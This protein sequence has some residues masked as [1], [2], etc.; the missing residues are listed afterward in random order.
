MSIA[1]STNQTKSRSEVGISHK[2]EDSMFKIESGIIIPPK[3]AT[4]YQQLRQFLPSLK[5]KQS[6]YNPEKTR[7]FQAYVLLAARSLGMKVTTRQVGK[8]IRVWRV[9]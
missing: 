5:P 2:K 6:F 3:R 8:G 9:S 4:M 7:S 1:F